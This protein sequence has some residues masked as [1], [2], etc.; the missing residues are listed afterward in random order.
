VDITHFH[1]LHA[2]ETCL[3][4]GNGPNLH[5]TPPERFSLPSF[6]MNTIHFYEGWKPTYYVTVDSVVLREFGKAILDKFRDIPKFVPRPNLDQ[7]TTG[8]N[9]YHF[10][11]RPGPLWNGGPLWSPDALAQGITYSNV[12]HVVMQI[13]FYMGFKIMLIIGMSHQPAKGSAH[14][15]GDDILTGCYP[16]FDNWY[17]GYRTLREGMA[18]HGVK[19]LNI[20][21]D[22]YVPEDVLP[23]GNWKDWIS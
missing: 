13:A 23:R 19:I 3:L 15:W 22:T 20:S 21:E 2:G 14:F 17:R 10:Y 8:E 12:M 5:L 6:G 7:W 16:N 18:E 9:F 11:H 1:N 4:V